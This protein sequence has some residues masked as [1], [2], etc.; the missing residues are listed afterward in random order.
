MYKA[1]YPSIINENNIAPNTMRGKV[2]LPEKLDNKED[3]FNNPYFDRSVWFMEDLICGDRLNF[4]H[5]YLHLAN[6]EEMYDDII[7]YFS[8]IENPL[9]RFRYADTLTGNRFMYHTVINTQN[10]VM[11]SIVD[12]SVNRNMCV[13]VDIMP[14][15]NLKEIWNDR[16]NN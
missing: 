1:L 12:N 8:T 10:R 14:K 6:Y 16:T 7:K 3:R 13:R 9:S 5:R 11:C 15:I 2:L 4:C